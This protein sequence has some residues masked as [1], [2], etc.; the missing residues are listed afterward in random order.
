MS[1]IAKNEKGSII[2]P[3]EPGTYAAVCYG[4]I[5]LGMQYN[6]T[7]KNYAHKIVI[8]WE[9]PDEKITI[10]G[11]Q[12]SRVISKTFTVSLHERANLRKT[13]VSWR[14]KDFTDEELEGFDLKTIVGVP[15]LL[16][17]MPRDRNGRVYMEINSVSKIPKGMAAPKGTLDKI[18][19]DLDADP[20]D[21]IDELPEWI[22]N[23]I[24]DNETYK[25]RV[26]GAADEEGDE[27][28]PDESEITHF[29]PDDDEEGLPF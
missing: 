15:C 22:A 7:F 26:A 10:N 29:M 6:D 28:E 23:Q 3:L 18:I 13:L 21:K 14:G 19:F 20:L 24:K 17:L 8:Q 27:D 2:S 25:E 5:D 4:M 16:G 11:E 1:L 9:L 12:V